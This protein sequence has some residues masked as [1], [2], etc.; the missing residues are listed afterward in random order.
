M[1][2]YLNYEDNIFI[3]NTRV[4][5]LQDML[6][7]DADTGIFMEKTLDDCEFIGKSA[8]ILLQNLITNKQLIERDEQ[9]HNLYEMEMRFSNVLFTMLHGG[10]V[11]SAKSFPDIEAS[12]NAMSELSAKRLESIDAIMKEQPASQVESRA[13]SKDELSALL[14][15]Q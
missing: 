6:A 11:I 15:H 7:L 14:G 8:G 13:V 2:K 10:N 3:L 1:N 12:L 5:M 4:R 9:L